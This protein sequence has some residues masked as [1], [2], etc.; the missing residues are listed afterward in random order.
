VCAIGGSDSSAG[1]GIQA[2]IRTLERLGAQP[3]SVVT[4]VTAQSGAAVLKIEP[5]RSAI[6]VAQLEAVFDAFPIAAVKIGMLASASNVTAVARV[7]RRHAGIPIVV[8]PVLRASG[9]ESLAGRDVARRLI[10][11]LLPIAA[12]VTAHVD[13]AETQN[14]LRIADRETLKEAPRALCRLGPRGAVVKGGHLG[15]A[16]GRSAVDVVFDGRTVRSIEGPRL[17][18][19]D[20]HGSGC[21][22][23]SAVAA[24]LA[25]GSGLAA[26]ARAAK[27]H[28]S[29]LLSGAGRRRGGAWLRQPPPWAH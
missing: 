8:D 18:G 1:A 2:D 24:R 13:E 28:V 7:L 25:A 14:G 5:V 11:E 21:A 4:A 27:G 23:A 16:A 12:C 10:E 17:V 29:E 3:V 26:A 20:M 9:G 15:A 19:R 6:V 22:Y